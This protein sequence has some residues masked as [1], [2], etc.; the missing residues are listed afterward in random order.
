MLLLAFQ[1][2]IEDLTKEN[3]NL[4]SK[5]HE[6]LL[7]NTLQL[8]NKSIK[9]VIFMVGDSS[10]T[11]KKFRV[12]LGI[13]RI[14]CYSHRLSLAV[15]Q[16]LKESKKEYITEKNHGLMV[17]LK[18]TKKSKVLM[19]K[20]D[21]CPKTRNFTRWSSTFD[22]LIRYKQLL[23]FI[24][25][26]DI[27]LMKYALTDAELK[28]INDLIE[29]LEVFQSV[30][31]LQ[32]EETSVK[33][34][35]D[36]F[37]TLLKSYPNLKDLSQSSSCVTDPKFEEAINDSLAFRELSDHQKSILQKFRFINEEEPESSAKFANF[38]Q[39]FLMIKRQKTMLKYDLGYIPPTS[40]ICE[41]FFRIVNWFLQILEKVCILK[42]LNV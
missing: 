19:R 6:D 1:P 34:A 29:H 13:P 38:A 16:F 17:C 33:D 32:D 36:L 7:S 23:P 11:N 42:H 20:T 27:D 30:T 37:E 10:N 18:T 40:N 14:A 41:L 3:Y 2:L 26:N 22:M 28:D 39:K 24:D 21:L 8:Y 12:D 9:N 35:M 31:L 4:G 5:D 15:K 25:Q